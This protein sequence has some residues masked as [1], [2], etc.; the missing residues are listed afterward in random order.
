MMVSKPNKPIIVPLNI[1][2][3]TELILCRTNSIL[4]NWF[5]KLSIPIYHT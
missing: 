3:L 4:N 5:M 1:S 2:P